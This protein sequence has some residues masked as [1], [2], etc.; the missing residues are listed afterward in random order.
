MSIFNPS[1]IS[2]RVS[3]S[4]YELKKKLR[5]L[6]TPCAQLLGAAYACGEPS[7]KQDCTNEVYDNAIYNITPHQLQGLGR[8]HN[9]F[10]SNAL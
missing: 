7:F 4:P 1:V 10:S 9:A 2:H 8:Y 6:T 5:L 3:V